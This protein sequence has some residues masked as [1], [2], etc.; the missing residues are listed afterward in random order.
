MDVTRRNL[1]I[2]GAVVLGSANLL[3]SSPVLA[4]ASDEAAVDVAADDGEV[5]RNEER[6]GRRSRPEAEL[7]ED[8]GADRDTGID[9]DVAVRLDADRAVHVV[10]PAE[11]ELDAERLALDQPAQA[12]QQLGRA[13]LIHRRSA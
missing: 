12:A 5:E 4:D 7:P 9:Q 11:I 2:V 6:D 13:R 10:E 3:G 1:A 8:E